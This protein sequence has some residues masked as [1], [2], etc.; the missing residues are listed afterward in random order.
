MFVPMTA[1][2][3]KKRKRERERERRHFNR[4]ISTL[5]ISHCERSHDLIS[6]VS[7][8]G[9]FPFAIIYGAWM[10]NIIDYKWKK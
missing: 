8:P 9:S 1:E 4:K 10:G 5:N 2:R 7:P 6:G 3:K